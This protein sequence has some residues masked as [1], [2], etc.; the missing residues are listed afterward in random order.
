MDN[1]DSWSRALTV[2]FICLLV[3]F[4]AAYFI[5]NKPEHQVVMFV[6]TIVSAVLIRGARATFMM[7]EL[8][9]AQLKQAERKEEL[10]LLKERA[11]AEQRELKILQ[12]T[13]KF[14]KQSDRTQSNYV[15]TSDDF[16]DAAQGLLLG[17]VKAARKAKAKVTGQGLIE[18]FLKGLR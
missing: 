7:H 18:T 2:G 10:Q 12:A 1:E 14:Q 6:V 11:T 13:D 3:G 5:I 4:T 9:L 8:G 15:F 16:D 17:P